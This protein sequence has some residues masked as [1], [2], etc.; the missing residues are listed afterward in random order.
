M[1]HC[2]HCVEWYWHQYRQYKDT[3]RIPQF[4]IN[5]IFEYTELSHVRL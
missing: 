1:N 2:Q 3:L 5:A 4:I